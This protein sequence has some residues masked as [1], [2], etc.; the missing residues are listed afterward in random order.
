VNGSGGPLPWT[1]RGV[2]VSFLGTDTSESGPIPGGRL[3]SRPAPDRKG[4]SQPSCN[5]DAKSLACGGSRTSEEADSGPEPFRS[6]AGSGAKGGDVQS[7][8]P[9][10]RWRR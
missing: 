1:A 4:P 10:A 9:E 7:L 3:V 8:G 5:C 2:I 6:D